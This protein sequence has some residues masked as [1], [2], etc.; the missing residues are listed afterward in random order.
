[1]TG[2]TTEC[3]TNWANPD[4]SWG[5]WIK[6]TCTFNVLLY[7]GFYSSKTHNRTE[8]SLTPVLTEFLKL[9]YSLHPDFLL[10]VSFL[11][12][13]CDFLSSVQ[14][15][16]RETSLYSQSLQCSAKYFS[17]DRVEEK[18]KTDQKS[19]V[20]LAPCKWESRTVLD[21]G[22]HAVDS[23]FQVL[24]RISLFVSRTWILDANRWW[25]S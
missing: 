19:R 16:E 23:G 4:L 2:H 18:R 12:T 9:F 21:S 7:Y 1:M 25:D 5:K 22:F 20:V 10:K 17:F 24:V 13:V 6:C 8:Y 14:M 15:N 11:L 3:S